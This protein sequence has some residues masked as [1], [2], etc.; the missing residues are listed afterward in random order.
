MKVVVEENL[1][2]VFV[3]SDHLFHNENII[4][5][6]ER[7]FADVSE[8]DSA[9]IDNWNKIVRPQDWIIHLGGFT[10]EGGR[11]AQEFF[12]QLNGDICMLS[13]PWHHD[14][15][16]LKTNLPLKS[17]SGFDVR[18]WPS[19]V[20]LEVPQLGK[21]GYPLAITLCHYPLSVWDRKHFGAWHLHG[22]S[23]GNYQY[24]A[25]DCALD[26]GVD[27]NKGKPISLRDIAVIFDIPGPC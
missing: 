17:K 26:V 25:G 20:V 24:V 12:A 9:L 6:R 3:T 27:S 21:N 11:V 2:N 10:L 8:M 18:L 13:Y 22:H 19:M 5:F 1:N 7:P 16:W 14:K 4:K 23:H 15:R